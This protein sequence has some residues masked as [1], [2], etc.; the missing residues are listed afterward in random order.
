MCC[1]VLSWTGIKAG[2]GWWVLKVWEDGDLILSPVTGLLSGPGKCLSI[3]FFNF[4]SEL[5]LSTSKWLEAGM[6]QGQQ[7][8]VTV[9]SGMPPNAYIRR[10]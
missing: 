1:V 2:T 10:P 7:R 8:T 6:R 5:V 9:Y 3:S 4:P